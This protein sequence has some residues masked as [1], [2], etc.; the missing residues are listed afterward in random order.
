M[1]EEKIRQIMSAQ[2][3]ADAAQMATIECLRALADGNKKLN[4]IL[5]GV[6]AEIRDV[7]ER[8]IRIE[9]A[10]FKSEIVAVKREIG[11]LRDEVDEL[12][13]TE[14]RHAGERSAATWLFKNW[15]AI[16]A[17]VGMLAVVLLANGKVHL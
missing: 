7:R 2:T 8:L 5:E 17:W 12:K 16:I 13:L 1:P 14:S 10:E 15:P 9:A 4:T 3:T 11:D 6:Q